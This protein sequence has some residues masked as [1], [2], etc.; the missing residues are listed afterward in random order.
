MEVRAVNA[1]VASW[2]PNYYYLESKR[3]LAER[4][5]DLGIVFI[6]MGNDLYSGLDTVFF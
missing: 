6:T 1:G 3:A 4:N 5:Y 2:G